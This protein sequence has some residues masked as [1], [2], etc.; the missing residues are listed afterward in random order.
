MVYWIAPDLPDLIMLFLVCFQVSDPYKRTDLTLVSKILSLVFRLIFLFLHI[1]LR[2]TKANLALP[3]LDLMS[4]SAPLFLETILP[5]YVILDCKL[6]L[7]T[8]KSFIFV[9]HLI[10]CISEVW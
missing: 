2:V 3:S 4:S 5:R 6:M 8:V 7:N 10:S 1:G 9:G